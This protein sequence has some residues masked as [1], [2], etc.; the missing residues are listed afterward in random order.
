MSPRVLRNGAR[1]LCAGREGTCCDRGRTQAGH[2]LDW[3]WPTVRPPWLAGG[4]PLRP[5]GK[6]VN[7]WGA[8]VRVRLAS[9]AIGCYRVALIAYGAV[10]WAGAAVG[11]T[12]IGLAFAGARRSAG[13]NQ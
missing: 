1:R 6:E 10:R 8:K 7:V 2:L 11:A 9:G 3:F 5:G 4:G 13:A 12:K